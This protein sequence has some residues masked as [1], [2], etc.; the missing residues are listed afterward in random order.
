[1]PR[2]AALAAR[3]PLCS[4]PAAPLNRSS[5]LL[6]NS[7]F[8]T[9]NTSPTP[10][11]T[12]AERIHTANESQGTEE[13]L[14]ES[15]SV[16]AD[17]L[18]S[19]LTPAVPASTSSRP[20]ARPHQPITPIFIFSSSQSS[21]IPLR[22]SSPASPLLNQSSARHHRYHL[23]CLLCTARH[24]A[25]RH[26]ISPGGKQVDVTLYAGHSKPAMPPAQQE[27]GRLARANSRHRASSSYNASKLDGALLV[28]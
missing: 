18:T 4:S 5:C 6:T 27:H 13:V 23:I 11:S 9:T 8:L 24:S 28:Y 16:Y 20:H 25:R 1:M 10:N 17:F 21:K 22:R 3:L 26:S 19:S 2:G 14:T 12:A 15:S 7:L